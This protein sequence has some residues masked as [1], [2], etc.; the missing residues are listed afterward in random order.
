[1]AVRLTVRAQEL[2]ECRGG[3]PG[4]PVPNR[5]YGV[6]GRKATVNVFRAHELC[7]SRAGRPGLPVPNSPHGLCGRKATLELTET[8]LTVNG[9]PLR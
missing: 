1:M 9:G 7:Q 3:R 4:L 6:C 8:R 5:P 2:R